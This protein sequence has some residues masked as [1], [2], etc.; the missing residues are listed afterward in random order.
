VSA[1]PYFIGLAYKLAV[2][3]GWALVGDG[4]AQVGD[5][6]ANAHPWLCQC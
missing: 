6:W 1:V 5:D 4:W 2:S 3:D